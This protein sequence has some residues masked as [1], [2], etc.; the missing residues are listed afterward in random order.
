MCAAL[1][2]S[3]ADYSQIDSDPELD[4]RFSKMDYGNQERVK[5]IKIGSVEG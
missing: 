3:T 2:S 1:K 4:V 5:G